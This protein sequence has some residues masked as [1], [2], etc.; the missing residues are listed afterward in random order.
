MATS[1]K[2]RKPGLKSMYGGDLD[3]TQMEDTSLIVFISDVADFSVLILLVLKLDYKFYRKVGTPKASC[4]SLCIIASV[5][6]K[7]LC[8]VVIVFQLFRDTRTYVVACSQ[9]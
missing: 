4:Q 3:S 5:I 2:G 9:R 7:G 6:Y 1:Q 8:V